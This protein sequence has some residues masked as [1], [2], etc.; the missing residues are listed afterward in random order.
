[1]CNF[2]KE[3]FSQNFHQLNTHRCFNDLQV[4]KK[5]NFSKLYNCKLVCA[6]ITANK[7]L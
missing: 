1:M 2:F 4:L 7:V 5:K 3:L 6:E